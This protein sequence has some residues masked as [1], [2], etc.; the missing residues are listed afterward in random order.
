MVV[1]KLNQELQ[2]GDTVVCLAAYYHETAIAKIT[3]ICPV[4]I[5]VKSIKD[6]G[7]WFVYPAGVV[8]IN[9]LIPK[10]IKEEETNIQNNES[11]NKWVKYY[12]ATNYIDNSYK[13]GDCG[14]DSDFPTKYCPYCGAGK[15][16][17]ETT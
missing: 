12:G 10:P 1:D 3:K 5:K 7:E 8:K 4:K 17:Y 2:I 15:I 9:N 13:C 6:N 16:N 14:K 11:K